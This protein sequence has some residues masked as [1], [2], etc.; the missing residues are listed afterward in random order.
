M[1]KSYTVRLAVLVIILMVMTACATKAIYEVKQDTRATYQIVVAQQKQEIDTTTERLK[2]YYMMQD[3]RIWGDLAEYEA[4]ATI[5][6]A[7]KH[8]VDL[9]LLVG[10]V[11]KESEGYPFAKSRTGAKGSGQVDF[12]AHKGRFP[13][14]KDEC[15]KYD[16]A[17]NIDCAAELL[18]EYTSKHGLKNGLHAYNVGETAFKRGVR[19]PRYVEAVL[20]YAKRYRKF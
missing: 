4:K 15:D 11:T 5:K 16:P 1:N 17:K 7:Q 2:V 19:N 14:I 6:A 10:V 3:E 12:A 13:H 18:K 8:H 20:K 9:S